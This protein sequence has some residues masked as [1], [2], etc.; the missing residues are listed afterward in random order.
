[1]G[2]GGQDGFIVLAKEIRRAERAQ[3]ARLERRRQ[4]VAERRQRLLDHEEELSGPIEGMACPGC[5]RHYDFGDD[6]PHC[7]TGLVCASMVGAEREPTPARHSL[8]SHP[9]LAVATAILLVLGSVGLTTAM[10]NPRIVQL[11]TGLFCG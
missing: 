10:A 5:L 4:Q 2:V 3:E 6:C 7:G 11:M 1:M 8:S 9:V